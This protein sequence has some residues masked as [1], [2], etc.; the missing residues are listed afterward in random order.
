MPNDLQ[1]QIDQL[2]KDL[3]ALNSEYYANN[4]TAS[5]DFNKTSRFN[6]AL[7]VPTLAT[8]PTTCEVGQMYC[9]STNG[10]FYGCSAANTWTIIGTQS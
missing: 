3:E 4:F 10:K 2:K 7:K 8:A 1:R 9:N 5:Q 6:T